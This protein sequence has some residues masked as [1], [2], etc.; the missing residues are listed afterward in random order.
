MSLVSFRT[1]VEPLTQG[2]TLL[3][4]RRRRNVN[5]EVMASQ[6]NVTRDIY[7]SWE[8]DLLE[9]PTARVTPLEDYE[10]CLLLRR[11]FGL[12]ELELGKLVGLSRQWI[13]KIERGSAQPATLV[14]YWMSHAPR[15]HHRG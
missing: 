3:I 9:G 15:L 8:L 11:R 7:Q 5:Q 13:S 12:S 4:Q 10:V 1:L 2:E 6:W 14:A